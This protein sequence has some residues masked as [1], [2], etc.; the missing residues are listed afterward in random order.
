MKRTAKKEPSDKKVR[1]RKVGGG[2]LTLG[3]KKIKPNQVFE[4]YPHEIPQAFRDVIVPLEK[5][6]EEEVGA[7]VTAVQPNYSTRRRGTTTWYDVVDGNDKVVNTKALHRDAA[8][9]LIK[10]LQQ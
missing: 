1:W 7:K 10:S 4:A 5:I 3:K 8:L 9:E 6:P 2:S